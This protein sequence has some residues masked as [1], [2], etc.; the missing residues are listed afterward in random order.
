M[1]ELTE[2]AIQAGIDSIAG[3]LVNEA[4]ARSEMPPA[5]VTEALLTSQTYAQLADP[6][7]GRYWDSLTELLSMF[8]AELE[9][10]AD[11]QASPVDPQLP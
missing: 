4:S 8:R 5:D 1:F 7:T 11:G 9:P 3:F 10:R 2:S 6:A